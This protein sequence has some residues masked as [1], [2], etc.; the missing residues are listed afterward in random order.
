MGVRE[1]PDQGP[2]GTLIAYLSARRALL[3]LDNCEHL[4]AGC[5]RLAD[6]LLRACPSLRVLATS[7]APLGLPGETAWRVP[8]MSLPAE[9]YRDPVQAL[10]ASDAVRLFVD[11]AL[12]VRPDF[13]LTAVNASAIARIC[14]GLDGIPL[15]IELAAARVR[16]LTPQQ[17]A[18]RLGDRF[19]LLSHGS[20]T[21][22]PRQ[23]TL[24]ASIDWSYELLSQ[25]ERT[26]LRR[27]SIFTGGWTLEAAEQVCADQGIDRYAV[28]DLLTGL[29]DQSQVNHPGTGHRDALRAAG[30]G[31][32]VRRCSGSRSR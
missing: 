13:R 20:R 27:L 9:V 18:H 7:R 14:H 23:Q 12:Q 22:V 17:I 2:L 5:A 24:Q 19:R 10:R 32:P 11:R 15:A 26:L 31:P 21:A 8:S 4:L 28:L 16:M 1:L 30:D 29:V 25:G 3:I 6:A